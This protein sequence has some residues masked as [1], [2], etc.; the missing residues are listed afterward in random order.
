MN[1]MNAL[2]CIADFNRLI[3]GS[4]VCSNIS[5]FFSPFNQ[6]VINR[7]KFYPSA[8]RYHLFLFLFRFC[9]CE[10]FC[11]ESKSIELKIHSISWFDFETNS[12]VQC[13][14]PKIHWH[15]GNNNDT[16]K[17]IIERYRWMHYFNLF[18]RTEINKEKI[19]C[20]QVN[21]R[22]I[23][24]RKLCNESN[25]D[26]YFLLRCIIE[27]WFSTYNPLYIDTIDNKLKSFIFLHFLFNYKRWQL[28]AFRLI[29]LSNSIYLFIYYFFVSF[30]F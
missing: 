10:R 19:I 30:Y 24:A 21:E 12:W 5:V 23:E 6:R 29:F 27:L 20:F 15:N 4:K 18:S 11:E 17:K 2:Y 25:R 1:D 14:N 7:F 3:Y 9:W 13:S 22:E 28:F 8:K 16:K 26:F